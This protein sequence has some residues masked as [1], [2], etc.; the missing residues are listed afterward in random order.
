MGKETGGLMTEFRMLD[1]EVRWYRR[2]VLPP[3]PFREQLSRRRDFWTK[4]A[5]VLNLIAGGFS[6]ETEI[7]SLAAPKAGCSERSIQRAVQSLH[8]SGIL[9]KQVVAIHLGNEIVSFQGR[10]KMRFSQVC[11]T[12]LGRELCWDLAEL[13]DTYWLPRETEWERMRRLHEQGKE[14]P[15]HTLAAQVFTW[16][17]RRRGWKAGVMPDFKA[18]RFVPDTVV[19]KAGERIYVE[20][21]LGYGKDAKW[22]NM[23]QALGYVAFCGRSQEHEETSLDFMGSVRTIHST[24]LTS[25]MIEKKKL[26]G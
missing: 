23:A 3:P 11:L 10:G 1:H 19:E 26:W 17:A 9:E 15:E 2:P 13:E 22:R 6:L 21:E 8:E 7:K 5:L 16:Q 20:V 18:G 14:E 25:L 4:Q 24:H 12:E